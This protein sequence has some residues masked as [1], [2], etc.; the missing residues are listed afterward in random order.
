MKDLSGCIFSTSGPVIFG[1]N[2]GWTY[3]STATRSE[4]VGNN[5]NY[6]ENPGEVLEKWLAVCHWARVMGGEPRCWQLGRSRILVDE[7][8]IFLYRD[9]G[10][11]VWVRTAGL[12]HNRIRHLKKRL[13]QF[14]GF[15]I[16]LLTGE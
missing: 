15:T 3:R 4:P 10:G 16:D 7:I 5:E 11:Q 2:A 13:I 9:F 6:E 8:G 1:Q 12:S 14:D